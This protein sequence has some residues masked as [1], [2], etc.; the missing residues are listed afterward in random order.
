MLVGGGEGA[1][2]TDDQEAAEIGAEADGALRLLDESTAEVK[3]MYVEPKLRKLGV[4]KGILDHLEGVAS[5]LGAH[6]L[7]LETGIDQEEAIGLYLRAGFKQVDCWGE[8]ATAPT[9]VCYQKTL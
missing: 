7:V 2:A 1:A 9:S 4:A 6:R 5:T 8:Y 3:R